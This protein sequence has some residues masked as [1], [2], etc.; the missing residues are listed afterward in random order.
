MVDDLERQENIDGFLFRLG[1][2]SFRLEQAFKEPLD[3]GSVQIRMEKDVKEMLQ[4][5]PKDIDHSLI[6]G[7]KEPVFPNSCLELF[8][9]I[10]KNNVAGLNI[11]VEKG[12]V[13]GLKVV[14]VKPKTFRAIRTSSPVPEWAG[15]YVW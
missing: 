11:G 13:F 8:E 2:A 14:V 1:E 10:T 3:A 12:D 5:A 6:P 15:V 4:I 7:L 9:V